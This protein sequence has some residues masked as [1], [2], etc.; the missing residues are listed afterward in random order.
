MGFRRKPLPQ[1]REMSK[2][3]AM[4]IEQFY[5]DNKANWN[6]RASV[7]VGS[8]MYRIDEYATDPNAVSNIVVEDVARIGPLGGLSVAHLQCH[9]GTDTISFERL[10]AASVVG[11]DFSPVAIA[12]ARELAQRSGMSMRFVE[13][14]VYDA[15]QAIGR[16]VDL[17]YTS[18]GTICW[19]HD[20]DSWAAAVAGL[21]ESGGRFYIRDVHPFFYIFD[22]VD[23][24]IVPTYRYWSKPDEPLTW[25]EDFT[26][27]DN[28]ANKRIANTRHH[29]WNHSLA[30]VINALVGAGMRID[31]LDE[32]TEIPWPFSPSCVK[33]GESWY[34]PEPLRSQVPTLFSLHA[35]KV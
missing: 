16:T 20:L 30:A 7:H 28:P 19:L 23:G 24:E 14:S 8:E 1:I 10:G 21:L 35:T 31:R 29:E 2:T 17:V 5:E 34:L 9:I 26:Y 25:D 4:A 32:H 18:I 15:P 33:E 12:A 22:E 13:A 27:S 3:G 11:L 6:D